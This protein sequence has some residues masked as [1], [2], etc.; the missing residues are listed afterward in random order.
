M[1]DR[2]I[3]VHLRAITDSYRRE[4]D[5]ASAATKALT[6]RLDDFDKQWGKADKGFQHLGGTM[7]SV[8]GTLTRSVTLPLAL[9]G[10]AAVKMSSDFEK[11]FAT[12]VGLAGVATE[13]VDGLKQSVLDLAGETAR[14]PQELAD[15]LYFA[16]SAGLD[17]K[18]AM[19]AVEL[20]AKAAAAGMGRTEEVVGLVASAIASY[21]EE[22]ITA[23]EATDILTA[24][25]REG[26]ADPEELAST[27]GRVLPIAA[28]LGVE[29][30]E[31]G[32]AVAYL[33]NVFGDTNRTVTA[34]QG[35]LV[36]LVSPSQQG[37]K[38]LQQMG[39]SI[40]D[41]HAAIDEDGLLGALELLRE[42]GFAENEQALRSL[43]DDIE[44]YQAALALLN[45][46]SGTLTETM[47]GVADSAG[48][49]DNAFGAMAETAGFKNAQA[50]A[51]LQTALI[52]IGDVLVPIIADVAE[53]VAVF[54]DAFSAL[55]GPMQTALVAFG[56]LL[57][58][59]GPLVSM[60]GKLLS[61]W[62]LLS[63]GFDA[64]AIGAY[65]MSASLGTVAK[66]AGALAVAGIAIQQAFSAWGREMREAKSDAEAFADSI[67]SGMGG[68][69][70][71]VDEMHAALI[72]LNQEIAWQEQ[73]A[74]NAVNPFLK[75]RHQEAA[76]ALTVTRDKL[77]EAEAAASQ[78]QAELGIS[79]DEA[80]R[81]ATNERVMAAATNDATGEL[82]TQA[83]AAESEVVALEEL[84]AA[85][86]GVTSALRAQFDPLFATTDALLANQDA[87]AAVIDAELELADATEELTRAHRE[88]GEGSDEAKAALDR[89]ERA[90]RALDDA[91]RQAVRSALDVSAA[92]AE[93]KTRIDSGNI[94]LEE[95]TRQ[96]DL[97]VAQGLITD[98]QAQKT[99]EEFFLVA[100]AADNLGGRN[101]VIPVDAD[102][103]AYERKIAAIYADSGIR[104]SVGGG[105][106]VPIHAAAG[107]AGTISEPTPFLIGEGGEP[108]DVLVVPH[109]KGGIPADLMEALRSGR[110]IAPAPV[111]GISSSTHNSRNATLNVYYP[112]GEPVEQS[113][114]RAGRKLALA[115]D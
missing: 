5:K 113:A 105:G 33:S 48:A 17:T 4:M 40:E 49:L 88:H 59:T 97:W 46:R 68:P 104:V 9:A 106:G 2:V 13:D 96:L 54:L 84:E 31:V 6:G 99:R 32:G 103:S 25:V 58:V 78:F 77:L 95:A 55:P 41:L 83:A 70:N 26:R 22:A 52:Q 16:A 93:L 7:Q 30:E 53:F 60:G 45:D 72:R 20:S 34:T 39:T 36:K 61:N 19:E 51:K 37:R 35:L 87:Q 111:S 38:A 107:Y 47:G 86:E 112:K 66:Q 24:T 27:L 108:E 21:G 74:S 92:T 100:L 18:Q 11:S 101:I 94:S 73:H 89:Q 90:Q 14:A 44:G 1:A 85:I 109:S 82:D 3:S 42:K 15:A 114:V 98:Q 56:G 110:S 23:A 28:Q 79:A 91:Q 57:A 50:F 102:T 62:K 71:S 75:E 43:F 81:M 10:G 29:F 67:T 8:G 76:A 115:L 12:M 80:A 63:R 69:V 64:A 65:N